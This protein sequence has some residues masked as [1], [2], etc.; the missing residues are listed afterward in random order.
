L[1]G[2]TVP[3][4]FFASA[5]LGIWESELQTSAACCL[6]RA[7]S[8]PRPGAQCLHGSQKTITAEAAPTVRQGA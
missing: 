4:I 6:P 2:T 8:E 1:A 5:P 7:V 3:A